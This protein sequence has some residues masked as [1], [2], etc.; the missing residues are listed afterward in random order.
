V[1][2]GTARIS[3]TAMSILP[4]IIMVWSHGERGPSVLG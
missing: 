3:G 2:A 1:D 4:A